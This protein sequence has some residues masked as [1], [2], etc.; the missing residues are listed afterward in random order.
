MDQTG[1]INPN[2]FPISGIAMDSSD[3]YG[4]TAYVSIM[5]FHVS[6][7]WQTSN[8]G[9]SW[10][11]FTANLPDA[12][13]N[14]ILVDP[15]TT[16]TNGTVYVG[17]DVGVFSSSTAAANWTEVGSP[18]GYLTN[19]AVT[20]LGVFNTVTTKLLRASTYGRGVWQFPLLTT[21]DYVLS[22]SP[23]T[24]TVFGS[25][26]A[27]FNGKAISLFGYN[28]SVVLSCTN[29]NTAPPPDCLVQPGSVTPSPG[30]AAFTI[31]ASSGVDQDYN[32]NLHGVGTDQ[33]QLTHDFNLTLHVVDFALTQ[34]SP[35]S[36][37]VN[38]PNTS[39]PVQFQVTA[40]GSFNAAVDLSCPGHPAGATC[41][42]DPSSVT[43]TAG[44]PANV[45]LTISAAPGTQTGTF[46]I[47]INGAT[48]GGPNE[49]PPPPPLALTI[50][51]FADYGLAAGMFEIGAVQ[52]H[53]L[54][55]GD[56]ASGKWSVCVQWHAGF[57][58]RLQQRGEFE[59]RAG[60]AANVQRKSNA[61][62]A[63][64]KWSAF[65]YHHEKQN[66]SGLSI[67]YRGQGRRSLGRRAH[68]SG[69]VHHEFRFP[70]HQHFRATVDPGQGNPPFTIS[71]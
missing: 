30:G 55:V 24:L 26:Q 60:C 50:T 20:A 34:P 42:F 58:E 66:C 51:N 27:V 9:G 41:N 71:M 56:G 38:E 32:F 65:H 19:V 14:A 4:L 61:A 47:I 62:D 18:G 1:S 35:L 37:S 59:L 17:T 5:G 44:K 12:P 15:G 39:G 69:E 36:I 54:D 7:V 23:N 45:I 63:N 6:H 10:T 53:E 49:Q 31:T 43:P 11:D 33:G 68:G 2:N 13:A 70:D 48:D 40:A 67:R 21:P 29:G 52:L 46:P 25:G 8:G 57:A 3:K 28:S 16:P 22:V 64:G